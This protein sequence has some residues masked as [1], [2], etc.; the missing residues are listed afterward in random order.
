MVQ[1]R[2]EKAFARPAVEKML[3]SYTVLKRKYKKDEEQLQYTK[4][5]VVK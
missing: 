5:A 3:L 1:N 4:R 2:T